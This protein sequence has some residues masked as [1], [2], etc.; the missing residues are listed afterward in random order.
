MEWLALRFHEEW[1]A[2][3]ARPDPVD[4]QDRDPRTILQDGVNLATAPATLAL[5]R[6]L[7]LAPHPDEV[8]EPALQVRVELTVPG[9]SV[10]VIGWVDAIAKGAAAGALHVIDFKTARRRWPK[11][12]ERKELQARVY[13]GGLWQAGH[14]FASLAFEYIVFVPGMTPEATHVQRLPR[15]AQRARRAA[16]AWRC[17]GAA[18]SRSR[19]GRSRPTCTRSAAAPPARCTPAATAGRRTGPAETGDSGSPAVTERAVIATPRPDRSVRAFVIPRAGGIGGQSGGIGVPAV[20]PDRTWFDVVASQRGSIYGEENS[21]MAYARFED[22]G[23]GYY[24]LASTGR[25]GVRLGAQGEGAGA[26]ALVRPGHPALD[27]GPVRRG[28]GGPA[29]DGAPGGDP[30]PSRRWPWPARSRRTR[31]YRVVYVGSPKYREDGSYTSTAYC[32]NEFGRGRVEA[33]HPGGRPPGPLRGGPEGPVRGDRG[34]GRV[35]PDRS[36][37]GQGGLLLR[38][39]HQAGHPPRPGEGA[40]GREQGPRRPRAV[41]AGAGRGRGAG[42]PARAGTSRSWAPSRRTPPGRSGC[43]R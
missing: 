32:E 38:G 33:G 14:S 28:D 3:L 11:D 37:P 25:P 2:Q 23:Y 10:P 18:G 24:W 21:D 27:A 15:H 34:R 17:S 7:D 9:V 41:P 30:R 8:S 26:P 40:P 12:R 31:F 13:L 36:G 6:G 35:G 1:E 43:R 20:L 22:S 4:W 39:G 19:R 5:L 29:G 42:D 16:D